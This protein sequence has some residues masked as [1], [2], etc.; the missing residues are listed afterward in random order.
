MQN[1]PCTMTYDPVNDW[2]LFSGPIGT[3]DSTFPFFPFEIKLACGVGGYKHLTV[4]QTGIGRDYSD[5]PASFGATGDQLS[6]DGVSPVMI[7]FS[8]LSGPAAELWCASPGAGCVT[9]GT[10]T[11]T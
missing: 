9:T 2:Y 7:S 4:N 5:D 3:C 1:F 6:V 8:Y 11:E 10:I